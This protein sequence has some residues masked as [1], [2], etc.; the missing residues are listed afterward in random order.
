MKKKIS[1]ITTLR[2]VAVC[3][4]ISG[5]A[6]FISGYAIFSLRN[7]LVNAFNILIP[8]RLYL[9][10]VFLAMWAAMWLTA[11]K[12]ITELRSNKQECNPDSTKES[13]KE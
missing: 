2:V 3:G 12:L 6:M 9:L 10:L 8:E 1:K 5:P 11:G 7:W 13:K 4:L